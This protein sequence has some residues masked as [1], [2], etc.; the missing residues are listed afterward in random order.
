MGPFTTSLPPL[1]SAPLRSR[2]YHVRVR[3]AAYRLIASQKKRAES[4]CLRVPPS[5]PPDQALLSP[6]SLARRCLMR[7]CHGRQAGARLCIYLPCLPSPPIRVRRRPFSL[8][9]ALVIT[10]LTIDVRGG[11]P[12][13]NMLYRS[14][15][16]SAVIF[17][18]MRRKSCLARSGDGFPRPSFPSPPH[19]E[20]S[21][22]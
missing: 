15:A 19:E 1:R 16:V 5:L 14:L 11:S 22:L 4:A 3:C 8:S 7:R 13:T 21:S 20:A 12:I 9:L 6:R 18:V 2:A 17:V 10:S